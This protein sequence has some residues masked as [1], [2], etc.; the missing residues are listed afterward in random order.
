VTAAEET[1]VRTRV[2]VVA[3]RT[4]A[5][6]DLLDAVRARA[7]QGPCEFALLIP[8]AG[9][10]NRTD[11]TPESALPMLR[12]AAGRAV[13][14]L[15]GATDSFATVAEAVRSGLYDELI[16]STLPHKAARLMHRDLPQRI[17]RLGVPVN[18]IE[19]GHRPGM[20]LEDGSLALLTGVPRRG[21]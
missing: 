5:T 16:V 19:P 8:D 6:P 12:R 18:V 4:A 15:D 20:S 13:A 17:A 14:T 21:R 9:S 1:G 3:N 2:L 11:W 10:R 7:L